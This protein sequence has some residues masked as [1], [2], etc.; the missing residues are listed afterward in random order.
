MAF[1]ITEKKWIPEFLEF[2]GVHTE[3]MS[4]P[5]NS[6]TEAG[7]IK[8]SL[9]KEFGIKRKMKVFT[10]GHDHLCCTLGAGMILGE[11]GVNISGSGDTV[12]FIMKNP[13]INEKMQEGG[14]SC[15]PYTEKN[16]YSTYGLCAMSGT[17]LRWYREFF[18]QN[19]RNFYQE[20]D[21]KISKIK[22]NIVLL[23][24]FTIMGTPDFRLN[25]T[26]L[27]DGF[28]LKTSPDELYLGI[29]EGVHFI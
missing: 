9:M 12:S 3:N 10:G 29:L 20:I 22:S 6:G 26:G 11:G 5:V 24:G 4:E 2:A 7:A 14:Y 18:G 23:P 16:L 15:S 21:N 13:V 27:M 25:S 8:D 1:N 17:L 19:Q 28:T